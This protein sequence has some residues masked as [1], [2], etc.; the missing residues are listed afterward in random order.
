MTISRTRGAPTPKTLQR[1]IAGQM[2][3]LSLDGLL[4][5]R[6]FAVFLHQR[7]LPEQSASPTVLRRPTMEMPA[8]SL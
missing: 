4:A 7:P 2:K 6:E 8:D 1:E 5:L 3:G